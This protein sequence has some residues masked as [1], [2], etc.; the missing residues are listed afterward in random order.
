MAA[1]AEDAWLEGFVSGLEFALLAL[2]GRD[3]K[4]P[5]IE[6]F[7][8]DYARVVE[9]YRARRSGPRVPAGVLAA[10]LRN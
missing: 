9:L 5:E 10:V 7:R 2:E 4:G 8:R 1:P 6:R 3:L